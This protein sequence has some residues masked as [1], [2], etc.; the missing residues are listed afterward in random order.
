MSNG[1]TIVNDEWRK[2]WKVVVVAYFMY[3][4]NNYPGGL[5]KIINISVKIDDLQDITSVL[6]TDLQGAEFSL[7]S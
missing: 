1:S 7:S 2:K 3:N 5:R 6:P 4:P